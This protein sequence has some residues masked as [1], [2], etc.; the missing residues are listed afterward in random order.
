MQSIFIAEVE[1]FNFGLKIEKYLILSEF[2]PE[3]KFKLCLENLIEES[4]CSDFLQNLK[5]IGKPLT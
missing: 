4:L 2:K 3:N 1:I 5:L